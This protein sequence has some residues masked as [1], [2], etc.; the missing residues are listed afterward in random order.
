[1]TIHLAGDRIPTRLLHISFYVTAVIFNLCLIIQ[2][3]TVG[4]AYFV[5][6]AWWNLHVWLVRGYGGLSLLLLGWSLVIPLP[7]HIQRL[8]VSL[9]ILLGLQ[10]ISIHLK[11]PLHLE[12]LHP[13]IGFSL[14]Y[15]SSSLVHYAWRSLLRDLQQNE[16]I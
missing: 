9:P 7:P 12:I 10:F 13:L 15:M 3:L 6:P 5:S 2:L 8:T 1:M 4:I 16:Q 11:S 14:L